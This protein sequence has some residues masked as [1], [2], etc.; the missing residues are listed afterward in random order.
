MH[1]FLC[2][3]AQELV[4]FPGDCCSPVFTA[5]KLPVNPTPINS[6]GS[7]I[8]SLL[9]LIFRY[10]GTEFANYKNK[11][12][13]LRW[14]RLRIA[15]NVQYNNTDP[16]VKHRL[17]LLTSAQKG[18]VSKTCLMFGV[19]RTYCYIYK[20]RLNEKGIDGLK[21][22][23]RRPFSNPNKIPTKIE[24]R[25]LQI[26]YL[27]PKCGC[28]RIRLKLLEE[29]IV[30]SKP[31]VHKYLNKYGR[32]TRRERGFF[33]PPCSIRKTNGKERKNS[34]KSVKYVP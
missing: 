2:T 30:I 17:A 9:S 10:L 27:Y 25:I 12:F 32:G 33:P 1:K 19:S 11:E 31:T 34:V 21:N 16:I 22:G 18:K 3:T 29:G 8:F 26:S 4:H 14:I 28:M 20:K 7:I 13:C 24:E 23:S 6:T 15:M 5:W